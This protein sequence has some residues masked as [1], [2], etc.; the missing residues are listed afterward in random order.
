MTVLRDTCPPYVLQMRQNE[1]KYGFYRQNPASNSVHP[2]NFMS[3]NIKGLVQKY[4]GGG[5]WAGGERGWVMG[6]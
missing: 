3:K 1:L 4:G 5:G 2:Q 6:F